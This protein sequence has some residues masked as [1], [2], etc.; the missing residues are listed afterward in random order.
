MLP[1][2][3]TR[4]ILQEIQH[5]DIDDFLAYRQDPVICKFQGFSP[6]SREQCAA[7]IEEMTGLPTGIPGK[8][9]Q[10]GIWSIPDKKLVGDCA[11]IRKANAPRIA[12][13]GITLHRDFQGKGFAREAMEILIPNLFEQ[14]D[15]HKILAGMDA[16]NEGAIN[17]IERLGFSKE[18]HHRE[19]FF[20]YEDEM[21]IDEV[22]YAMLRKD[23]P[24]FPS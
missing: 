13:V 19:Q 5:S 6:M 11:I 23:F 2:S 4:I 7:F 3:G 10:I 22:I 12:E 21:W 18:A 8:W 24:I 14:F 9:K 1:L 15:L 20:D 17:L 16:R